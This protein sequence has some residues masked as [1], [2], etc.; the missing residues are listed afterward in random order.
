MYSK[1]VLTA[2]LLCIPFYFYSRAAMMMR[3]RTNSK[4]L[5]LEVLG[6]KMVTTISSSLTLMVRGILMKVL[7][8]L[9][10]KKQ[11]DMQALG[12]TLTIP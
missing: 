12:H 5:S 4:K 8:N 9:E 3:N 1:V 6:H 2:L 11:E 7:K 10:I